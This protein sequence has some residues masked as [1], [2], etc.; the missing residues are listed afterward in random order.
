[1][2]IGDIVVVVGSLSVPIQ[3]LG[4]YGVV[5][6]VSDVKVMVEFQRSSQYLGGLSHTARIV[7]LEKIGEINY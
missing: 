4:A 5:T 3:F 7:D 1:M 2:N 6:D